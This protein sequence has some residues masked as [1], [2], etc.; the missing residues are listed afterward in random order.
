MFAERNARWVEQ[1]EELIR[2]SGK[3]LIVVGAGH[4]VGKES[5]PGMLYRGGI[6][7]KRQ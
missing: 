1:I 2:G 7:V 4:L 6:K 3:T 5:V